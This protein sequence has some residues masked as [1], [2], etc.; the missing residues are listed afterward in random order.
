MGA[1]SQTAD[2]NLSIK[3]AIA[4]QPIG[5]HLCAVEPKIRKPQTDEPP[6]AL[7]EQMGTECDSKVCARHCRLGDGDANAVLVPIPAYL[8]VRPKECGI[9]APLAGGIGHDERSAVD[10][11]AR[12]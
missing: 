2:S 4:R 10:V 8:C 6:I 11:Q 7:F 9:D 12:L 1:E 5:Q 3:H